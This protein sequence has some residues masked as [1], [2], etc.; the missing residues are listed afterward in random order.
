MGERVDITESQVLE[1]LQNALDTVGDEPGWTREELEAIWGKNEKLVIRTVK[2]LIRAGKMETCRVQRQNI[3]GVW[4][5]RIAY[6]L[7]ENDED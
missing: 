7:V 3:G 1:A 6:R 4:A 5:P 2:K